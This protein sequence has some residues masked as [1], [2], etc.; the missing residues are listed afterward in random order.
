MVEKGAV[1]RD[2]LMQTW[3]G[4]G[5]NVRENTSAGSSFHIQTDLHKNESAK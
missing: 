3:K 2:L 5:L 4:P 1:G